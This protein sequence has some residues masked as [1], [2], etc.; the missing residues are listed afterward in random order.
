[1]PL[2]GLALKAVVNSQRVFFPT[3]EIAKTSVFALLDPA[4]VRTY[5]KHHS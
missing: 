3:A 4:S 5:K 1:V 2:A